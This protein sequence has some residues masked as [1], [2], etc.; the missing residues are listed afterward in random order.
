ML[1]GHQ[2][3]WYIPVIP[4]L[5]W[6]RQEDLK[7]KFEASLGYIRPCIKNTKKAKASRIKIQVRNEQSF[8]PLR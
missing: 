6:M 2:V 3:C 4:A 8:L 7:F 1:L 5:G